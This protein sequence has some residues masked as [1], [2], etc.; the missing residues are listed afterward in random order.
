MVQ[1][2]GFKT[3]VANFALIAIAY[4]TPFQK[5]PELSETDRY[6]RALLGGKEDLPY[7]LDIWFENKK[8]FSIQWDSN[9]PPRVD[10]IRFNRGDWERG[11]FVLAI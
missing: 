6:N 7:G 9:R 1:H 4:R 5:L 3:R 10:V 11:L 8:P 2:C